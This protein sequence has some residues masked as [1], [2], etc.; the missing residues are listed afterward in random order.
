VPILCRNTI[1]KVKSEG[2]HTVR[3]VNCSSASQ[4]GIASIFSF[5][6]QK[7]L[8]TIDLLA[9]PVGYW[10]TL[11]VHARGAGRRTRCEVFQE[12]GK[13][14]LRENKVEVRT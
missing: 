9:L 5:L 3:D 1:C 10:Y 6:T 4:S 14:E 12:L 11:L 13:V 7:N 2:S 8:K